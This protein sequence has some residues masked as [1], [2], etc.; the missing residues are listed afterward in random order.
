M[1]QVQSKTKLSFLIIL[2]AFMAFSSLSTDAY[3]SAM[4]SM[5]KELGGQAA[6]TVTG[7]LVGFAIAQL[8]WGPISDRIGRLKPLAIGTGIFII[9][10]IGCALAPNMATVVFF[11]VLQAIGACV[12]PML[13]R[14]MIRDIY[15]ASQAAQM[16]STLVMIMAIAPIVGPLLGGI[17]LNISGWR[18]IFWLMG[19]IGA[20][21]RLSVRFLPET[22]TSDKRSQTSLTESFRNYGSLL[23]NKTFLVN[24]I[25]VTFFYVA[26][27][28]FITGSSQVYIDYFHISSQNYAYYFGVN[29]LG[30]SMVSMFNR[31]LVSKFK[32]SILLKVSTSI[33]FAFSCLLL[34]LGLSGTWGI[35]GIAVPMFLTF[36]M[37]GIVAACS[38]AAA[39]AAVPDELTGS[40]AALLGSLQYG[41]G[42]ISSLLLAIFGSQT[43]TT[44]V[45]IFFV[46]IFFSMLSA[47]MSK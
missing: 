7:F 5:Q 28:A 6:L 46:A 15:D 29:V 8:I 1:S 22:L 36:S 34:F 39:L 12:G 41:S 13:S 26:I 19:I 17:L 38:N 10:S 18:A 35:W 33:A 21:L 32:L 16:L 42:I 30:I 9:G 47:F 4:P 44:M 2:S 14:A 20:L 40:A 43:P 24:T 11:R 27:Y 37:N 25:S 23:T 3:L 31:Q 45:I